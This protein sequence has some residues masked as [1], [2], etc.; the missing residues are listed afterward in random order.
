MKIYAKGEER[1]MQIDSGEKKIFH[2]KIIM[3]IKFILSA[4]YFPYR[5]VYV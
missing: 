5:K 4:F 1:K 3:R 2:I